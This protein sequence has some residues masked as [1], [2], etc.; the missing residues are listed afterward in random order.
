MVR[1][2]P[3]LK[4]VNHAGGGDMPEKILTDWGNRIYAC[5]GV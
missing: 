2:N 4:R 3:D 1:I 5:G